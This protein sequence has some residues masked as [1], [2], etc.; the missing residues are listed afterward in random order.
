MKRMSV[1]LTLLLGLAACNIQDSRP[2]TLPGMTATTAVSQTTASANTS[3]PATDTPIPPTTQPTAI[4]PTLTPTATAVPPDL[5]I[6]STNIFLYPYPTIY[7]GDRVTFQVLPFVPDTLN[8][9]NVNVLVSVNGQPMASGTL[10]GRNLSGQASG[11]FEWAWDT[12]EFIGPQEVAILL[13]PEDRIQIGDEDPANNIVSLAVNILPETALPDLEADAAWVTAENDCCRVHAIS[14]TAAYR[15][16]PQLL[17]TIDTAVQQASSTVH[18]TLGDKIDI[19]L[20]DRVIGQG[21]YAASAIVISY[22]D[23]QYSGRGLSEVVTHETVHILDRQFAPQRITFMAEGLAVWATGGHYKP[24][25]IDHRAS[26]L[27]EMGAYI[28]LAQLIDNFYPVQHEIGYLE[29]AAFVKFMVERDGWER[30]KAFYSDVTAD[31][32]PLLSEAVDLNLQIYYGRSLAELEQEWQDYLLQK[33]P[34]KDDIDDLQTTLR[35]YDLMR[36]YQLEYDPTAYFLT[37]W[38]P[39]PQDVLDKGNPADF[40]RH[41]QEEINVVL[42]VMFQGVDEALRDADYGR[43]N[44]LLDS[45][46]RVMDN[47]GAFL[48]PL[49]INY[50]HI[51][52]KATQLG[53]EVQQVTI[54]GDT[55]VAT[56][57]APQNTNLIHWNLAL[58]GQNWII[59]SN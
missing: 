29:A 48:D 58:K 39:Y 13:D 1:L 34:S 46:T 45:I 36:R 20:I 49:G 16:L 5:A 53:F 14:G 31:D 21:G 54:S 9:G 30:F 2:D 37:A 6:E 51:V 18:T 3:T 24:E 10:T 43:A 19:Y 32:A 4:P 40:T 52:Q 28:P 41:P 7:S 44:G 11:L 17:R 47:D 57:T 50:Q 23:R 42:E 15:D 56:V 55:A 33:P 8:P 25:D 35:Y 12:S 38:L 26:A 59:L 27:V 22:L